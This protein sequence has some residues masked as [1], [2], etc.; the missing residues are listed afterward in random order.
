M[1]A[2]SRQIPKKLA[3]KLKFVCRN[4]DFG[5]GSGTFLAKGAMKPGGF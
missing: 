3:A 5:Q 2:E 4:F 1:K